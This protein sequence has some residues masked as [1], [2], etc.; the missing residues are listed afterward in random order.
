M[1]QGFI[2]GQIVDETNNFMIDNMFYVV[3]LADSFF[4]AESLLPLYFNI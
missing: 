1:K 4:G 3:R 2:K